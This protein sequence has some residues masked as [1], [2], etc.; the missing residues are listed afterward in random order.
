M[1]RRRDAR[2]PPFVQ[3]APVEPFAAAA[4]SD[5]SRAPSRLDYATPMGRRWK[6]VNAALWLGVRKVVFASGVA[7]LVW[8]CVSV[9]AG[10]NR[11]TGPIVAAWGAGLAALM[12]PFPFRP[13]TIDRIG[14]CRCGASGGNSGI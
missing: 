6:P 11:H 7:M 5:A 3:I 1:S 2:A 8:G 10:V 9:A 13:P 14:P 12:I 4:S